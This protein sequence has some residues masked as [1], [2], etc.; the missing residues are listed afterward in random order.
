MSIQVK[1]GS[2][3]NF[4]GRR[5]EATA[6]YRDGR[7]ILRPTGAL[8]ANKRWSIGEKVRIVERDS[9]GKKTESEGVIVS[10]EPV[11]ASVDGRLVERS[12]VRKWK[13]AT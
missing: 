11:R 2:S 3:G 12:R 9:L 13:H 8:P 1:V 7:I 4:C 6:V 5:F 10:L